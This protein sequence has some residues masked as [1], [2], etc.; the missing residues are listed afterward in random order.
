MNRCAVI[1]N[2]IVENIIV[3]GPDAGPSFANLTLVNI[4]DDSAVSIGWSYEGGEFIAPPESL[5]VDSDGD[6]TAIPVTEV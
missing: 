2:V 4:D 6:D 5:A 3:I 1:Q